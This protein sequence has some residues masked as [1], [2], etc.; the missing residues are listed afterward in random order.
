MPCCM[1]SNHPELWSDPESCSAL[2]AA[3]LLRAEDTPVPL[4]KRTAEFLHLLV[5]Q[6]GLPQ[7]LSCLG[8]KSGQS[9][10]W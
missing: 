4:R 2:Q 10:H 3:L 7:F 9:A 1:G 5:T 8:G 6:V